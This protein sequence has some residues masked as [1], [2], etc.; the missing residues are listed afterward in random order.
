MQSKAQ[1]STAGRSR[2]SKRHIA[3]V[4]PQGGTHNTTANGCC[5]CQGS[6]TSPSPSLSVSRCFL[7]FT[8][9]QLSARFTPKQTGST[10]GRGEGITS[11]EGGSTEKGNGG[12]TL[13]TNVAQPVAISVE[14]RRVV[15]LETCIIRKGTP[16]NSERVRTR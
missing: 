16:A 2:A 8:K 14:L 11:R 15:D 1:H 9:G 6:H 3:G 5:T 10:M 4:D 13:T 7:F 12:R